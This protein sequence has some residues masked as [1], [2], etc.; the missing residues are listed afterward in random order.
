M[1][2]H[3]VL[4]AQDFDWNDLQRLQPGFEPSDF[5]FSKAPRGEQ[6]QEGNEPEMSSVKITYLMTKV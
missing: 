2:D 5:V 3:C 6:N 1:R 4:C